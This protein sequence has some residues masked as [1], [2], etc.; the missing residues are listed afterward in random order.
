M[1]RL[2][3][4]ADPMRKVAF[5]PHPLAILDTGNHWVSRPGDV[6]AG[7]SL[8][9]PPWRSREQLVGKLRQG[10]AAIAAVERT[11][12]WADTGNAMA[13]TLTTSWSGS[14]ET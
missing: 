13:P 6:C 14:G 2:E 4:R 12:D 11:V 3:R 8:L 9:H 5:R 10:A 1:W 7:V